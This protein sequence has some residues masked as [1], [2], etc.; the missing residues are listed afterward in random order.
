MSGV[1]FLPAAFGLTAALAW[2]AG[3][4][5]GGLASRRSN[6]F[7]VAVGAELTGLVALIVILPLYGEAFPGWPN[8]LLAAVAGMGGGFALVLFYRAL[9]EGQMS[10]AAPLSAVLAAIIPVLMG[11]VIEGWPGLATLL[12]LCLAVAAIALISFGEAGETGNRSLL[13]R[14]S[15]AQ[16]RL[17]VIA[18]TVFG[19][20]FVL[21]HQAS[22]E[23]ILWPLIATR[24]ASVI[25]LSA[26]AMQGGK[27]WLPGRTAWP[28]V[29]LCG[30]LDT[31]ANVLYVLAGQMGRLDVA[32]VVSSLYPGM[33][34]ALAWLIL[35]ERLS[36]GQMSGILL[37]LAAI[38]L[39]TL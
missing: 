18:G 8:F 22:Q 11:M 35:R 30:L 24:L 39:I 14:A 34:V 10:I 26:I 36:R 2:G 27:A 13:R 25:F 38:V 5:A 28:L 19:L 31:S 16:L 12:G 33:T 23:Q 1:A 21:L 15:V 4:F 6:V 32:A 7:G 29:A 37:A 9:A 17:P 3:D 20:Y